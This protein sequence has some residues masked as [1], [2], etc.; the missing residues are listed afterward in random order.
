[1]CIVQG[2]FSVAPVPNP[3]VTIR[4]CCIA[5]RRYGDASEQ[6]ELSD[7]LK[8]GQTEQ[9]VEYDR[10]GRV[11]KGAEPEAAKSKYPEDEFLNNH[12]AVWGSWW[13]QGSWGFACCHS[14]VK[15]S[16]CTGAA[17]IAASHASASLMQN[18]L[19]NKAAADAER[20]ESKLGAEL[21]TCVHP[22]F[23]PGGPGGLTR[24]VERPLPSNQP[25]CDPVSQHHLH[26]V[27]E[28]TPTAPHC[29]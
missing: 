3:S 1:L 20:K 24:E 22:P 4:N 8:L 26:H 2:P 29:L 12:T 13:C 21:K 16:Y 25:Q 17:G 23:P 15:N 7:K 10:A 18:N 19:A 27:D 6:D 28:S 9:Y 14:G 5:V 11:V